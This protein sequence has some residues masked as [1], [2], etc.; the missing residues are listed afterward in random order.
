MLK[1]A[2]DPDITDE[3]IITKA[4]LF[5]CAVS[6]IEFDKKEEEN[7]FKERLK[8]IYYLL[9]ETAKEEGLINQ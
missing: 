3:S 2:I 6:L 5:K 1:E 7:K 4:E 8:S 9:Q